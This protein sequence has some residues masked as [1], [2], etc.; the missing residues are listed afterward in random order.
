MR[1][2]KTTLYQRHDH[3][4]CPALIDGQRPEHRCRGRWVA[5]IDYGVRRGKRDRRVLYGKTKAEARDKLNAALADEVDAE[6]RS[7]RVLTVGAWLDEWLA[8][9]KPLLRDASRASHAAKIKNYMK[10]TIGHVRLDRLT[11]L[12]VEQIEARLTMPCPDP[13]P[14]GRCPHKPSHG[15]SVGTARLVYVVLKDALGDAVKAGHIRRNPA[16]RADAP[17]TYQKQRTHLATPVADRVL[18]VAAER[19]ELARWLVALECGLRQSEALGLTWGLVDLDAGWLSVERTLQ[20]NGQIG[21][22]K[23]EASRRTIPLPT[24]T[25]AA[26]RALRSQ[27]VAAGVDVEPARPVF[28][29]SNGKPLDARTDWQAWRDL[30]IAAGVPHV[31][32]H[33]ARQSAARRLNENGVDARDAAQFL[34]HSNVNMTY[35]Y[36]RGADVETLRRA[37]ER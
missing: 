37:I 20:S 33:S 30:L 17:S 25:W 24:R 11:T 4:S 35:R 26:L 3:P 34:G 8:N 10:P 23:S 22:P 12:Q 29:R 6:Q 16:E 7:G 14:E 2:L 36:Q 28:A 27:L 1:G 13:T 9:Y 18:E 15:L 31:A 19:G 32:L 21:K 5:A